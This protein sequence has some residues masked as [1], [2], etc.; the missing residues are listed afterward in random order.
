MANV[1]RSKEVYK[2]FRYD[3]D[4]TKKVVPVQGVYIAS[5]Y[6]PPYYNNPTLRIYEISSVHA[7]VVSFQDVT[8]NNGEDPAYK[9]V[10]FKVERLIPNLINYTTG[11]ANAGEDAA[12]KIL[13]FQVSR[14]IPLCQF[15]ES[16]SQ[17]AGEDAAYKVI[18]FYIT[19]LNPGETYFYKAKGN[20]T[21][22]PMLRLS[23]I[24][25]ESALVENYT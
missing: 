9:I 13:D 1:F 18:D 15:Y 25:S 20:S 11:S 6:R 24:T 19:R 8:A 10:D 16:K 4:K 7:T 22:E 17:N 12:Y 2:N 3:I 21:P 5:E 14:L 23:S